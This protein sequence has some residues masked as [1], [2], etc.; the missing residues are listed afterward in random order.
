VTESRIA[1]LV[2]RALDY[3]GYVTL[4]RSDGSEV[5]GFVYNRGSTHLDLLDETAT[6][7]TRVPLDAI[8]DISFSGEDAARKAQE[9]WE[10]RKGKLEPRDTPAH[11]EWAELGK[12][13]VLVALPQELHSVQRALGAPARGE[14]VRGRI[15]GSN[16]VAI[17]TGIAGDARH[18]IAEQRPSVVVSCGFAGGLDAHLSAGDLVLATSVR[19]QSGDC[20]VAPESLRKQAAAALNGLR[21]LE[22]ELLTATSVL[23]AENK[24]AFA[25]S[26]AV[27][28][29]METYALARAATEAGVPWLALRAIVDPAGSSLPPFARESRRGYRWPAMRHAMSGPRAA[30]ELIR[31]ASDARRAGAALEAGLR[32]LCSALALA[33]ARR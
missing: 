28:V 5:V 17:A 26:G 14:V 2:E 9:I 10:R 31:L 30:M 8:A 13:L 23:T 16:V 4:R 11:G 18:A 24:R 1:E 32:R 3:R 15:S 33:E 12:I 25:A 29:D 6:Q 7:R 27:A 20:L 19:G 22:G 21:L